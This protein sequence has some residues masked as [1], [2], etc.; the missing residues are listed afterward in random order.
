MKIY[1]AGIVAGWNDFESWDKEEEKL[2][3]DLNCRNRLLSFYFKDILKGY[4]KFR[5]RRADVK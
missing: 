5:E 2:Y 3:G 4:L 1:F